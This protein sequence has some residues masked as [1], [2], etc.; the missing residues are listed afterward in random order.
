LGHIA[1]HETPEQVGESIKIYATTFAEAQARPKNFSDETVDDMLNQKLHVGRQQTEIKEWLDNR[2]STIADD[3][4]IASKDRIASL[5]TVTTQMVARNLKFKVAEHTD[6]TEHQERLQTVKVA[7]DEFITKLLGD[8]PTVEAQIK[9]WSP[10]KGKND[11]P[12]RA[13]QFKGLKVD[14]ADLL[15]SETLGPTDVRPNIKIQRQGGYAFIMAY[16]DNR[17]AEKMQHTDKQ[18]DKRIY[19]NPDIEAAPEIFEEIF[20]AANAAGMSLQLKMWQRVSEL[21]SAHEKRSKGDVA[22]ALRADGIVMYVDDA[23][24][25]EALSL[26]LAIAQD[27]PEA[28]LGREVSRI[29]TSVAEGVAVGAEP[30]I[31]DKSLTSHR[32]EILIHIADQVRA[33]GKTGQDARDSFR[34]GI[35]Y[36]AHKENYDP[37]NIAF[38]AR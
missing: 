21:S 16:T 31:S 30:G 38:N 34:R 6:A 24:A 15:D 35:A 10:S 12:N 29:P 23:Q 13:L 9:S 4:V 27:R 20:Q 26:V 17:V 18:V 36:L 8:I 19:L 37:N 1:L 5:A 33:S 2:E 11:Y 28:F 3:E 7:K 32:A 22:D 14:G 25:D